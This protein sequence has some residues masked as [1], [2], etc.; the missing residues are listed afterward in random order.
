VIPDDE[1]KAIVGWLAEQV[2]EGIDRDRYPGPR[3]MVRLLAERELLVAEHNAWQDADWQPTAF[4][5]ARKAVEDF[6]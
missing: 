5:V 3:W 6:K 4:F 1:I 2:S